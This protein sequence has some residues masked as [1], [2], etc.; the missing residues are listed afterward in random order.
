MNNGRC[1]TCL[2]TRYDDEC[3]DYDKEFCDEYARKLADLS[4]KGDKNGS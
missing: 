1:A 4:I 3:E 2:I